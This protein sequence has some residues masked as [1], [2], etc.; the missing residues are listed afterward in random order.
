MSTYFDLL[1]FSY[2]YLLVFSFSV[3]YLSIQLIS[4]IIEGCCCACQTPYSSFSP[5][6]PQAKLATFFLVSKFVK[7]I[8]DQT[9]NVLEVIQPSYHYYG[10]VKD[11][12]MYWCS[13]SSHCDFILHLTLQKNIGNL[14]PIWRDID[15]AS[16]TGHSRWS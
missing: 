16:A 4:A 3:S 2:V 6:S 11:L 12:M 1:I 7:Q 10:S 14:W 8:N 15:N 13:S 5:T 9:D